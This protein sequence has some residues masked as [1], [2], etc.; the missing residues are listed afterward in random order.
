MKV[1]VLSESPADEIVVRILADAILQSPTQLVGGY[2]S[3]PGGWPSVSQVLPNVIKWAHY[4]T[5][6]EAF[7][8]VVDSNH[9][10]VH[11]PNHIQGEP[12]PLCR[13]CQLR[14]IIENEV[15][16]LSQISNRA[17][18]KTGVGLA[19]PAIEAWLLC[20]VD[21]HVSEAAWIQG[22][23]SGADPYTKNKLKERVYGTDRPSLQMEK[24]RGKEEADRLGKDTTALET[25]FPNGFGPLAADIR[26]W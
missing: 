13:F 7:I 9:S 25:F 26:S 18:L 10:P 19:V 21:P 8:V 15:A 1:A 17:A 12:N 4:H 16:G 23:S 22:L 24:Q 11:Q 20:G 2:R 5:D 3:R 14:G 6:A